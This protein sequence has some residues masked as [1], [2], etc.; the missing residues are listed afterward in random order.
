MSVEAHNLFSFT[1]YYGKGVY[2][3][4]IP[5]ITCPLVEGMTK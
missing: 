1:N 3:P 5:T 4:F 2:K